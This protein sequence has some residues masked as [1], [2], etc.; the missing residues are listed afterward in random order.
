M[1]SNNTIDLHEEQA[2]IKTA[3]HGFLSS[4][5][6]GGRHPCGGTPVYFPTVD[7]RFERPELASALPRPVILCSSI[8]GG[9]RRRRG[10]AVVDGYTTWNLVVIVLRQQEATVDGVV[11]RGER[12][13]D[14]ITGRMT[15]I[16]NASRH[17]LVGYGLRIL[18]PAEAIPVQKGE[19]Y[20]SYR[21]LKFWPNFADVENEL[22]VVLQ[23]DD[24]SVFNEDGE[25]VLTEVLA[26]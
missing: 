12:L 23:E 11:Y 15:L 6:D 20:T 14:L 7:V 18:K 13:H 21:E 25:E 10:H 24:L 4:Y 19:V 17:V 1:S 9:L 26:S 5:F 8:G 16:L 2:D 3:L 22:A